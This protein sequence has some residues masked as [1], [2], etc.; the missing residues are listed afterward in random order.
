MMYINF[1]GLKEEGCEEVV[2]CCCLVNSS[3]FVP[4]R[5]ET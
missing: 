2:W 1:W 5:Y 4:K 3:L